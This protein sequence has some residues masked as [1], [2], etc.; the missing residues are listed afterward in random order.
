MNAPP[1]YG[2][3]DAPRTGGGVPNVVVLFRVYAGLIA[4]A[5]ASMLLFLLSVSARDADDV[6]RDVVYFFSFA[7]A[8]LAGLH[9]V[10]AFVPRKPWG[11]ALGAVVLALGVPSVTVVFAIPLLVHWL[12]P[13]CRAAFMRA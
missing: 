13:N 8:C 12:R 2:Y 11:W 10:A 3:Y 1:P 7:S 4:F 6:G 5:S 9:G